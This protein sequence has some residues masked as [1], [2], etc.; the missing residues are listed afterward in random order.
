VTELRF[1]LTAP[2]RCSYLP[3]QQEQLVF[4]LPEQPIDAALYQQLLQYNFR[5]SG[6]QVY[7]PNCPDCRAC[8]SVRINPQQFRI[9]RSQRRL[10][11]K[12]SRAGWHY[13]LD[14]AVE[15]DYFQL[16]ADYIQHKHHDGSMFPPAQEQLD[17]MLNCSWLNVRLLKQ[18]YQQQLVAVTIVDETATAFSAVYT[19]YAPNASQFSPGILAVLH[20][21]EQSAK[22][23]KD[24]LYLGYQIDDCKKMAYKA[25][26]LPQQRFI[27]GQ[28]HS[29]G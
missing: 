14:T 2:V 4:L 13:Q 11:N 20:L 17:R 21:L 15:A 6:E 16:F 28:W 18:Y 7:T 22:Q 25:A 19:F 29:F 26:F 24:W 27:K 10:L 12:A 5:R 23:Q 1:G 9:S 8:Q 3:T